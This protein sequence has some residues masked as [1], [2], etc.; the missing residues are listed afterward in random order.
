MAVYQWKWQQKEWKTV[1]KNT[2]DTKSNDCYAPL[3][4]DDVINKSHREFPK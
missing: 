1:K 2:N 4:R 3:F